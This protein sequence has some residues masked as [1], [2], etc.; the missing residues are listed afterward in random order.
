[1]DRLSTAAA[2]G[3]RARM[4]SLELLANNLANASTAGFKADREQFGTYPMAESSDAPVIERSWIDFSQGPLV[5]TNVPTHLGLSGPG[6]LTVRRGDE[7][8]YTRNGELQVDPRGWLATGQGDAVLATNGQPVR[9]DPSQPLEIRSDGSVRQAGQVVAQ[10]GLFEPED[11]QM[12]RKAGHTL[13][14]WTG[15]GGGMRT[16][17]STT[18]NQGTLEGA[19]ANPAEGAVRLVQVLRQFEALQKAMQLDG[20]MSRR[21]VEEVARV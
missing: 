16:A 4:E 3:M 20:D 1:M 19:N 14:R 17:R 21:L 5:R 18:V 11:P 8:L 2:S 6:L 10:L 15:E 13:F 7:T 12:L 9:I